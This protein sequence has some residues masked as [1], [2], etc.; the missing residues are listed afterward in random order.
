MNALQTVIVKLFPVLMFLGLISP[1]VALLSAI[2]FYARHRKRVEPEHR[3]PTIA[4]VLAVVGCGVIFG[5]FG[6]V[7]GIKLACNSSTSS[8]LCGLRGVLR[9]WADPDGFGNFSC[10]AV[11]LFS[12]ACAEALMMSDTIKV[13]RLRAY[14]WTPSMIRV[15]SLHVHCYSKSG[16]TRVL[17]DCP[18]CA[19][20]DRCTAAKCSPFRH[21]LAIKCCV[22]RLRPPGKADIEPLPANLDL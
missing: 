4:Y 9:Y 3:V 20:S 5:Y 22:D 13:A 11:G 8:N 15:R 6:V 2:L 18:L 1:L 21:Q 14:H 19:N 12:T 17:S 7:L 10:R 16:Q